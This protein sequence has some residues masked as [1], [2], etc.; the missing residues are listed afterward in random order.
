MGL[1]ERM[2]QS[3]VS[4]LSHSMNAPV[5]VDL[6]GET[7]PL[8]IAI[9]ELNQKKIPLIIR[10]YL[11]DGWYVQTEKARDLPDV[12]L[13]TKTGRAKNYCEVYLHGNFSTLYFRTATGFLPSES[14]ISTRWRARH[15]IFTCSTG[16]TR[17]SHTCRACS[18]AVDDTRS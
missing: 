1:R 12:A 7:D 3:E 16:D 9:K 6:E 2:L 15:Q 17:R 8:Q 11:P 10:R 13:G 5:L 18:V 4:D 14:S